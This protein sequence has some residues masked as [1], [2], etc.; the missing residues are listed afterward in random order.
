MLL[1]QWREANKLREGKKDW[2]E[3]Y[4]A[5]LKSKMETL[6]SEETPYSRQR[7]HQLEDATI[8]EL[9]EDT[10]MIRELAS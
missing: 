2:E 9:A 3:R 5:L 4:N 10:M 1:R 6:R 8:G 7:R